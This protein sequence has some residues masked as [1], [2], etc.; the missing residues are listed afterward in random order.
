MRA[1]DADHHLLKIVSYLRTPERKKKT[2]T[3]IL[4]NACPAIHHKPLFN[5][6]SSTHGRYCPFVNRFVWSAILNLSPSRSSS[7]AQPAS[8]I[9]KS[10]RPLVF[11]VHL[12]CT[13]CLI[14]SPSDTGR[15]NSCWLHA[16]R[17]RLSLTGE[18]RLPPAASRRTP[19]ENSRKAS[20]SDSKLSVGNF[21]LV[22]ILADLTRSFI[23]LSRRV[24]LDRINGTPCCW[25][26]ASLEQFWVSGLAPRLLLFPLPPSRTSSGVPIP[27]GDSDV[28]GRGYVE[29]TK[30]SRR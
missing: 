2:T 22:H 12:H 28:V 15:I 24:H 27:L 17:G 14:S 7:T 25:S 16:L 21:Y 9:W 3:S 10:T 20:T 1:R 26:I 5:N 6:P 13:P 30:R 23:A 11:P 29:L 19:G 18:R 4:R 8:W